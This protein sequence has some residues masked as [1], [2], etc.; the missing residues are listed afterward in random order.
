MKIKMEI[1]FW[2]TY[3]ENPFEIM[4]MLA[5]IYFTNVW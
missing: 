3:A 5:Q 2:L 1:F 4:Q